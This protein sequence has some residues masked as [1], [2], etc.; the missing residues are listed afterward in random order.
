MI[1][2]GTTIDPSKATKWEVPLI[3]DIL[4]PLE[5]QPRPIITP[6]PTTSKQHPKPTEHLP[7]DHG[8]AAGENSK[9]AFTSAADDAVQPSPTS[10]DPATITS[11]PDLG[12]FPDMSSLA[13][14]QKWFFVALGAVSLFGIGV[15]VF[16]WRRRAAAASKYAPLGEESVSMSAL[17]TAA[18]G[19]RTTRELYD[20]FGE[21]SDDDDNDD[22]TT[23][24]RPPAARALGFHSGFLD[25]DE[26]STA[27]GL[28]PGYRDE[29]EDDGHRASQ[30]TVK[31]P[32]VPSPR[33]G[34]S[35]PAESGESWEHA[36]RE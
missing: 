27:A 9:P 5:S 1:L 30:S 7:G 18:S 28:T 21:V 13:T 36:S 25:D 14:G 31:A 35:S 6:S 32:E 17:G 24:L 3:D 34:A 29:P 22:E 2:W 10:T 8:E 11:S 20:A 12:W 33:E 23:A 4:P 26:P 19:P 16:F 15:G